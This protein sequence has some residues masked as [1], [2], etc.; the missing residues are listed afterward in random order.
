MTSYSFSGHETFSLRHGWLKKGIDGIAKK[1]NFFSTEDAMIQ[2]GVGKN[3][4]QAIRHWCLATQIVQEDEE[5]RGS[6]TAS[7]LGRTIFLDS[8][9]DPHLED[10]ATLWLLHWHLVNNRY[11]ATTWSWMFNHY[12][13]SEFNVELPS[14]GILDSLSI[15]LV[16]TFFVFRSYKFFSNN[17][18]S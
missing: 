4:V 3:M 11:H 9:L 16:L 1:S 13:Y 7:T 2:L 15:F 6:L 12:N 17:K 18:A 14:T 10:A 8:N 5:K